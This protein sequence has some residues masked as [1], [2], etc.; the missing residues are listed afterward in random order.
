MRA[1]LLQLMAHILLDIL[2]GVE[3]GRND[4]GFAVLLAMRWIAQKL[5]AQREVV[6]A[7]W[8][9]PV[10]GRTLRFCDAQPNT[11]EDRCSCCQP[12]LPPLCSDESRSNKGGIT[13]FAK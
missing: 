3:E 6:A 7:E 8:Q 12:F 5:S 13:S 11:I 10:P 1:K 4:R 9:Q 2:E